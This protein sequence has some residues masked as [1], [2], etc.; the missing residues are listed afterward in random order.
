MKREVYEVEEKLKSLYLGSPGEG[1]YRR[2]RK[3][4][5]RE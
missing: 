3:E 1:V 2:R 5:K 4:K